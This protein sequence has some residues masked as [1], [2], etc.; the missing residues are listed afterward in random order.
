M[1]LLMLYIVQVMIVIIKFVNNG[2]RMKYFKTKR[3]FIVSLIPFYYIY[4]FVSNLTNGVKEKW[5][6][7]Q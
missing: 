2:N 7:L 4:I 5:N 6:Q 3:D 1:I